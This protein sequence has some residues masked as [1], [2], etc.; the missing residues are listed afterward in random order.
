MT[1]LSFNL[2]EEIKSEFS[3]DSEGKAFAS[4]RATARLAGVSQEAVR[5][6]LTRIGDN[7]K[8]PENLK[9]FAGRRF[10]KN[11]G[12][13]LAFKLPDIL[14]AEIIGYYVH[15]AGRYN[16]K[17]AKLV[18]SAFA[19]IGFRTWT[20]Q[21]L[22]YVL[23]EAKIDLDTPDIQQAMALADW[24]TPRYKGLKD[25]VS[26]VM[27]LQTFSELRPD[28][29]HAA[30]PAIKMIAAS[31]P[32]PDRTYT[33]TEIGAMLAERLGQ[34]KISAIAINKKLVELGYQQSVGRINTKNKEVHDYY[35][36]TDSGK[37]FGQIELAA[38][39]TSGASTT[40][41]NARWF[42]ALVDVLEP[43]WENTKKE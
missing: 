34:K 24:M 28:L 39:N 33:P 43:A 29:A 36:P 32:M 40:K 21:Q 17:Q 7:L 18:L 12:D 35:V 31:N 22:G 23:P 9:P 1:N 41:A 27:R 42:E 3:F 10:E 14:V 20:Q 30:Q 19:A 15:H 2:P 38:F 13:N 5:K 37:E 11:E 26:E 16:T 25:T 4:Q 8:L 6:L